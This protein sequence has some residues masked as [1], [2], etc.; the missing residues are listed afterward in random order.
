M[1]RLLRSF[2][3]IGTLSFLLLTLASSRSRRARF[4]LNTILYMFGMSVCSSIGVTYGLLSCLWP[5]KR[6]NT[7]YVVARSF[8]YLMRTLIGVS[9]TMEGEKNLSRRPAIIVGNH[10]SMLDILYLGRMF[11]LRSI[12]MA[13][14]ELRM[15]PLLGQ[16]MMLSGT[17]FIDRKNRTSALQTMNSIGQYMRA[18]NLMLFMFPEGTRSHFSTPNLLPFKKGAFHLAVQTQ[19]PIVPVVCEN[20]HSMYDSKTRFDRG[21]IRLAVLPPVE[22]TGMTDMDVDQLSQKVYDMMKTQLVAFSDDRKKKAIAA[23]GAQRP[24]L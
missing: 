21:N 20:Y 10:Q 2:A 16:F 13:K 22:T 7:N 8:Y 4:Y 17:A 11:P 1:G 5:G 12:I 14:K 24:H 3:S 18:N 19:L 6:L 23:P 15:T 9:V